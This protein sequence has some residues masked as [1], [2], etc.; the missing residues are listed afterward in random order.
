MKFSL[1]ALLGAVNASEELEFMKSLD[2]IEEDNIELFPLGSGKCINY[3]SDF[4]E[5]YDLKGFDAFGRDAKKHTPSSV[6]MGSTYDFYFKACQPAWSMSKEN[7]NSLS[8]RLAGNNW[9]DS[10]WKGA[11]KANA[12]MVDGSGKPA[13][14]FGDAQ[15]KTLAAV[16]GA[17]KQNQGWD[18]TWTS[19]EKT[20]GANKDKNFVVTINGVCDETAKAK[21]T[22]VASTPGTCTETILFTGKEACATEIPMQKALAALGPFYGVLLILV[23]GLMCFAGRKF[24]FQVLG[25]VIG[26]VAF[27]VLFGLSY[28]MFLPVDVSTGLLA[29]VIVVCV[30]LGG[31]ISWGTFKFTKAYTVQILAGVAGAV[32]FVMLGKMAK[33][34]KAYFTYIFAILGAGLGVF[35]G[36]KFHKVVKSVA[37]ALIGS[38]LLVWGIGQYAPGYPGN[39]NIKVVAKNPDANM[40]AIGYLAGFVVLAIAGFIVQMKKFRD[41]EEEE[42]EDD[43]FKGQDEGRTCGCF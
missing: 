7:L 8:T 2:Q 6:E 41:E 34:H 27:A 16:T 33:L 24:I 30:I 11:K 37:T 5:F 17:G 13:Y 23:G 10:N 42:N 25:A 21:S 22:L 36:N 32:I 26:F 4:S 28:A 14:T 43:A 3:K 31:L 19:N 18:I 15:I 29:G 39:L 20:C 12:F 40:E 35:L 9:A 38:Y 1:L